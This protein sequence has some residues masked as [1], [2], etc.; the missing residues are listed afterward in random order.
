MYALLDL[1]LGEPERAVERLLAVVERN[2]NDPE[3]WAGLVSGFRYVDMIDES[4]A[5]HALARRLDPEIRTSISYTLESIGDLEGALIEGY[6]NGPLRSWLLVR[7]G[8]HEEALAELSR[9]VVSTWQ[10]L[11][12]TYGGVVRAMINRDAAQAEEAVRAWQ[13][14][15][16]PEGVY[17]MARAMADVGARATALRMFTESADGGYVNMTMFRRDPLFEPF[18]DDPAYVAVLARAQARSERAIESYRGRIPALTPN[19]TA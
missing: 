5:C 13:G 3:G 14:F 1:D 16:D 11:Q 12:D 17:N 18:R 6:E 7:L 4:F 9:P 8:R 19:A 15:P 2:P 10:H